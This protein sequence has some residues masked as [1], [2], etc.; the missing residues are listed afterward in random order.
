M[1]I[2]S[3]EGMISLYLAGYKAFAEQTVNLAGRPEGQI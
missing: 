2:L 1:V 3:R